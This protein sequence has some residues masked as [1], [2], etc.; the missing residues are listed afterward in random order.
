MP[1]SK[2]SDKTNYGMAV[3]SLQKVYNKIID[4][5]RKGQKKKQKL[6]NIKLIDMQKWRVKIGTL[7]VINA[8]ACY[9]YTF[10]K[11]KKNQKEHYYMMQFFYHCCMILRVICVVY[12]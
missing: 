12:M 10:T 8:K 4:M 6:F 7:V 9:G 11:Q 5:L 2:C 3:Y 1:N